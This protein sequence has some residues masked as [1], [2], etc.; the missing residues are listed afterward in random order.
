M[1][2]KKKP[3]NLFYLKN[4]KSEDQFQFWL[5]VVVS[6]AILLLSTLMIYT[7]RLRVRNAKMIEKELQSQVEQKNKELTSY[8]LN[9]IQKN[10]L[11]NELTEKIAELKKQSDTSSIKELNQMNGIINSSF[12]MDHDWDNFKIMFEELHGNFFVRL[13]DRFP[14]L[15]NAELKLCALLRLNMNLKESSRILGISS[16]SVKTARYRLRKKFGLGHRRQPGRLLDKI[17]FRRASFG[18]C[19]IQ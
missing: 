11:L 19:L 17:R 13:K 8:A 3:N 6:G 14:E 12:R 16:D 1:M 5:L 15:G 7:L 9:F 4:S 10:E 2:M 18:H